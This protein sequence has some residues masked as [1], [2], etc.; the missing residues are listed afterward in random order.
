MTALV[1]PYRGS[2]EDAALLGAWAKTGSPDPIGDLHLAAVA[3]GEAPGDLEPA[4]RRADGIRAGYRLFKFTL[5]P[6]LS[7]RLCG[8]T[9]PQGVVFSETGANGRTKVSV[10]CL[11]CGAGRAAPRRTVAPRPA[12]DVRDFPV[13]TG[14]GADLAQVELVE[15]WKETLIATRP[16]PCR[17][18][19]HPRYMVA[20]A[21]GLDTS[22]AKQHPA[23]ALPPRIDL[24]RDGT[25]LGSPK[26][27]EPLWPA[28]EEARP[29]T[30]MK[31]LHTKRRHLVGE[32]RTS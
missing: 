15:N 12:Y 7:F 16:S 29:G 14:P 9:D 27:S 18:Y 24:R 22:R 32:G 30:F 28:H 13:T 4:W 25:L 17:V 11:G 6:R 26:T 31:W 20:W 3:R 19:L 8:C 1:T 10:A 5:K 23:R 2:L 21:R